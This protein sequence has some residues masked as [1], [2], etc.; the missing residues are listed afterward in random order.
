MEKVSKRVEFVSGLCTLQ[1]VEVFV[2]GHFKARILIMFR[3]LEDMI[4][5]AAKHHNIIHEEAI[6]DDFT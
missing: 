2:F 6:S 1:L 5:Y 3:E 4:I